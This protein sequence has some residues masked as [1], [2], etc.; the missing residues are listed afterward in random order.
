VNL[1]GGKRS[2]DT[3]GIATD[4]DVR[5]ARNSGGHEAKLAYCGN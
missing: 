4:P 5:L 2:N 1:R 3:H